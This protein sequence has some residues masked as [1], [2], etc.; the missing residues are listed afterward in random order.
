MVAPPVIP[1]VVPSPPGVKPLPT[2]ERTFQDCPTCVHMVRIGGGSYMMGHGS[3]DPTALP[4]H[5]VTVNAFALGQYPVT[6]GEWNACHL[7]GGCPAAPRMAAVQD[8][9]PVHNVSWDDAQSFIVWLSRRAG[10]P[11]RLPTESEWE[12]AA[13]AD[14]T[15]RYWWGDQAGTYLANCAACGGKQNPRAPLPVDTFQPNGF[16]LYD[17]LGGVAQWMQDCWYPS[18]VGAHADGAARE[19]HGC[20]KRVLRGGSFRS[21]L[22]DITPISRDSYDA[23]VRYL[24]N[25]FRVARDLP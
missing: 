13:R 11:Y 25:G 4:V 8:T 23:S 6:V 7:D 21:G 17:M 16:G 2:D 15:T 14:T 5:H 19:V 18:Y 9:T 22:D 12:Y 3:K 24:A 20:G 1:P 10:H